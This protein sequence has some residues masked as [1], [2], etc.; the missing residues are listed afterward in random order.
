ME[1]WLRR[2]G[3]SQY[4]FLVT[5]GIFKKSMMGCVNQYLLP[6]IEVFYKL[7]RNKGG[8]HEKLL[9]IFKYKIEC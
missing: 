8:I 3:K 6:K 1:I 4:R 7:E 5:Q 9:T 2:V